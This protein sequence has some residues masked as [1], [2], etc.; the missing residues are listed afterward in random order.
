MLER[1]LA[2]GQRHRPVAGNLTRRWAGSIGLAVAIG[3]AYF[4]AAWLSYGL[5]LKSE[6]LAVFWPASGVSSGFLI[7][8][9]SRARWPV[10]SGVI[11]AVVADHLIMVDPLRVGIVFALSD[12]AETLIIAGL[13]E[14]YFGTEFSLDRLRHVLGM[15]AAAVIGTCV[16]GIG[17]VT[18]SVLLRSPTVPILTIWAHW[19]A[20]NT[21]GFI[22]VAPLLIGLA[23]ALRQRTRSSELFEGAAALT[24][25]AAMTGVIVSLSQERW[26]TVVPVAWLSPM[27]LWLAARCRPIFAAAGAF[28]VS[29]TIVCMTVFGIGHFGDPGLPIDDRILGA[30]ASI[31]VV[32]LSAY[33]LAAL[34]AERRQ[35]EARLASSNTMLE[36]ERSNKLMNLEAMAASISH[37]VK[38]PLT[39]ITLNGSAL[40]RYLADTPPKLEKARSAAEKVIAAGHRIGQILDDI[41]NL[42]GKTERAPSPV[43]MNDLALGALRALDGELKNHNIVTRTHLKSELSPVMG[44]S[45]QLQQVI[46]NLIQNAIDAMDS[47]DSDR[48]VLQVRTEHNGSDAIGITV[49]DTGPGIDP[50]KS[51]D[52]FD[53]FITTKPHGMGLGLAICRM[54]VERHDGKLSV[55][56]ADPHGAI[57][58]I[59]LPQMKLPH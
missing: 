55:S 58:R 20:A 51:N 41:R 38:Q 43:N 56:S 11:V 22:A 28:I 14:C 27:L 44:H 47:V 30:Q 34:F 15:L 35:N 24:A 10:V 45:G 21:I 37:E 19:V 2:H 52:I 3:L 53:A 36:R 8:L 1:P 50:K 54:I 49:E 7:A 25:L 6:G 42:F 26:E 17:G 39:G 33:V 9:G 13:I 59:K 48:R 32:A 40:L 31:L 46:V 16:S 29:I 18:A 57:F 4:L 5:S 12:A 23:A